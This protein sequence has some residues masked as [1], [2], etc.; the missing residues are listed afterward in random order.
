MKKSTFLHLRIPFSFF[1]LPVF[2]LALAVSGQIHTQNLLLSFIILHLL[3]YPA[4][5]GY[6]SY[7]DKDEGSIGGL[8]HP[9]KVS[10]ELYS[11]SIFLDGLALLIGLFIS[12]E[13]VIMIFVYGMISKAYSHPSIRLKKY[14][15]LGWLV[16]GIFQGYFTF[17]L[18]YIAINDLSLYETFIW[19]IQIP[20][21]LST[22]LL[23]G[24]YP[25]TQIYQHKEDSE[26]GDVTISK[27]LGIMGTF[28]FT[29]V[30]FLISSGGF[31]YFFSSYFSLSDGVIFMVSMMPVLLYFG[32]WYL[33]VRR[34]KQ[35]AD[36]TSTMRLNFVSSTMLNSYF[37]FLWLS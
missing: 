23:L 12:V 9:P 19:P 15:I 2:L 24:S 37:I 6:N 26:R 4:S 28:H 18:S 31:F 36:F 21:I 5:N 11:V 29:A 1:L 27:K 34:D 7:F 13:F 14:P 33:Q 30:T 10:K 3:V 35:K 20:G 17:L 16:A 32:W 25:M 8:K 22:L